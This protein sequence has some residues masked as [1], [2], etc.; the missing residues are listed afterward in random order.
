MPDANVRRWGT[1]SPEPRTRAARGLTAG[2]LGRARFTKDDTATAVPNR[3][4]RMGATN[5]RRRGTGS[6]E[7]RTRA[8]HGLTLSRL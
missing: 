6:P 1:G 5:V 7:P 3:I 8:A 2:R 4:A